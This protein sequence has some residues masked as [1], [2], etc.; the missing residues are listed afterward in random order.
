[1]GKRLRRRVTG[2]TKTAVL[3]AMAELREELGLAPRSSR[4]YTVNLAVADWLEGGL[5]GRS[6]RTKNAYKEAL[7]PLMAKFGHSWSRR[8][9]RDPRRRRR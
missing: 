6:D 4:S 8:S 1:M 7:A 9:R 3:E 5:P 2:P